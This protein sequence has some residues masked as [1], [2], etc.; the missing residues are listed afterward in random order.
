MRKLF[1]LTS[2]VALAA[3]VS[4]AASTSYVVTV[5][6]NTSANS[7]TV[8]T[9]N[10]T[11]GVTTPI[12]KL[13]TG[14]AG[15]G[16]GF[17]AAATVTIT[18]NYRCIF[19]ADT[20]S[21]DI[22]AF[23]APSYTKVGNY[24]NGALNWSASGAGGSIAVSPDGKWLYGAYSG[25]ENIGAWAVGAGC[26]LTFVNSYT[27]STGADLFATLHVT[28]DG[29][30]LIV[31]SIDYGIVTMFSISSTNGSLTE[32]NNVN[33]SSLSGC[34]SAGCYPYGFDISG[35][36]KVAFFGDPTLTGNGLFALG[37]N[38]NTTSGLSNPQFFQLAAS[39]NVGN[40]T[41]PWLT[42]TAYPHGNGILLVG[43][44][45]YSNGENSGA[46]VAKVTPT[47]TLQ[48]VASSLFATTDS[49]CN[50][51]T[52]TLESTG[53]IA[54][55]AQFPNLINVYSIN[56]STG[57]LTLLK[58]NTAPFATGLLSLHVVPETR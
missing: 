56:A 2:L 41:F 4:F 46:V 51:C 10:T 6:E 36:S 42:R 34:A 20:G 58:S 19:V 26:K 3:S 53:N 7:A 40:S 12:K 29:K 9:L 16:G 31:P 37:L 28:P 39:S 35:D 14:G 1:V 11:T 55:S 50:G 30:A 45:G 24:S 5:D 22:A 49:S 33:F 32:V 13:S 8:F 23:A 52:G 15:L 44:S 17:F 18:S 57:A 21:D 54:V 48:P 43:M 27:P 25:S 47:P 38:I